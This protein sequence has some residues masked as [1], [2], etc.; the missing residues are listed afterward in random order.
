MKLVAVAGGFDPLHIGHLRQI[1]EAKKLGDELIII[2]AKDD[3]LK[4]KKGYV[5]MYF[6]ERK[7]ILESIVGV[8]MVVENIDRDLTCAQSLCTYR[9]NIFAKG[10]DRT[11]ENMPP[12][13]IDVCKLIDCEIIY[14]VGGEKIQSSSFLVENR[15][16]NN[17]KKEDQK[18][19]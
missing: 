1:K 10:G 2:L 8:D 9:P 13:E 12:S 14:D 6:K 15:T 16:K 4:E 17:H 7:E 18:E 19:G 3:Q 5:F 11:P